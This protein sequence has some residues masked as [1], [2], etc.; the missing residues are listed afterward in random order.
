MKNILFSLTLLSFLAFTS[1]LLFNEI[2]NKDKEPNLSDNYLS[3]ENPIKN[4]RKDVVDLAL[5]NLPKRQNKTKDSMIVSMHN[6]ASMYSLTDIEA[7]YFV[8]KWIA[9]NIEYDCYNTAHS[10]LNIDD[11][12]EGTYNNG[13]GVSKGIALLFQSMVTELGVKVIFIEGY[14]KGMGYVPRVKPEQTNH[15]W[16]IIEINSTY[17]LV[18][19]T[20][21]S[22]YCNLDKYVYDLKDSYFCTNP[23]YLIRTHFPLETKYQLINN[24]ITLDDF[25]RM[26]KLDLDFFENGF[27]TVSP[28]FYEL[29]TDGKVTFKLTYENYQKMAILTNLN[30]YP[31]NSRVE[32]HHVCKVDRF[33]TEAE[34]TCYLKKAGDYK[35]TIYGGP[36]ISEDH[37]L[38]V[39]YEIVSKQDALEYFEYPE[40]TNLFFNSD[41]NITYPGY[42]PLLKGTF[43]NFGYDT[44]YFDNLYIINNNNYRQMEYVNG[45]FMADDVYIFAQEVYVATLINGDFKNIISYSTALE[46]ESDPEPEFPEPFNINTK[47]IL[48]G[49][50]LSTLK[51]GETYSFTVRCDD[52]KKIAILEGNTFTYLPKSD[53]LYTGTVQINGT[54]KTVNIIQI[55]ETSYN[56]LYRYKVTE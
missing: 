23:E 18:D 9:E 20:W 38:L 32:L 22:G 6:V 25:V 5:A 44:K 46:S 16:D 31:N 42:N 19:A 35:I 1:S 10:P 2:A 55:F 43:I 56:T 26:Q 11:T 41:M 28:D 3:Y 14:A 8:Y 47:S 39:E 48:Y 51:V 34:I 54:S 37:P 53:G 13:T 7:A 50:L 21:G 12:E 45:R 24:T 27:K 52:A 29:N 49:P 15:H 40:V 4:V 30:Y 36:A 17:Y 33:E